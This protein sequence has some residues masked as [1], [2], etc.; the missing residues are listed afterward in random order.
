[1]ALGSAQAPLAAVAATS[2]ESVRRRAGDAVR[3]RSSANGD[4]ASYMGSLYE[5]RNGRG[6]IEMNGSG[7]VKQ[8]P[9][10]L[11]QQSGT[12]K[13]LTLPTVLTIGR[14]AA[15]PLL[16]STFY[17]DGWWATT[18]T[19]SIFLLAALTDWLDGYIARKMRLG[20]A[21]GAFLDP[22]ADKLM[23]SATLVLLCTKP[24]KCAVFGDVPW[25]LAAPS[26]TI[27]GREITMSSVREWAAS[28]NGR[29]LEA[30]AVNSFG[31]WKTAT[32]MTALTVLLASRDPRLAALTV[33]VAAGVVLLYISAGLA[34][35]TICKDN[36]DLDDL[37][38]LFIQLYLSYGKHVPRGLSTGSYH[39][40]TVCFCRLR[41]PLPVACLPRDAMDRKNTSPQGETARV[42]VEFLEVAITSIVFLKGFYPSEAFERRRYMNVVV[43]RARH[44]QLS[45]YIHSVTAGLLPFVQKVLSFLPWSL[46]L[47]WI[48]AGFW[49]L[50][51]ARYMFVIL[52]D[53]VSIASLCISDAAPD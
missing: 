25:L 18:A 43:H 40:V 1:M 32:Q 14:V 16:V 45:G 48:L 37:P 39:R 26:I 38:A 4:A 51:T 15:V 34:V 5:F 50:W 8:S 24:L 22:V 2:G 30:V 33:L 10:P 23:V 20:T 7:S 41:C 46:V 13:L 36:R 47:L 19:T 12:P 3:G 11:L 44:P 31:K 28:Q 9:P 53:S 17:M 6:E 52:P 42:L 27:I 49:L 35:W 29:A 21:F